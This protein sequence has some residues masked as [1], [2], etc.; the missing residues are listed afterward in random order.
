MAQTVALAAATA[1]G[2]STDIVVATVPVTVALYSGETLA[3]FSHV[4]AKILQKD[5]NGVYQTFFDEFNHRTERA[6][7]YLYQDKRS[8]T[9]RTPGTFA[10]TKDATT[11]KI[12]VFTEDGT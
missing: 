11:A 7:V 9:I 10:V 6:G 3:N 4:K 12:G 5:P 1:A 8:Y 2:T